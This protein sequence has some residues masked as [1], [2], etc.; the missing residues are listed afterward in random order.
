MR[1]PFWLEKYDRLNRRIGAGQSPEAHGNHQE[2]AMPQPVDEVS[3]M[4]A[5]R[6]ERRREI[7]SRR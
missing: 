2:R 5:R 6:K 7:L 1:R 4:A 3:Q